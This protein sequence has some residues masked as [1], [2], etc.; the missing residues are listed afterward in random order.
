VCRGRGYGSELVS[1][2]AETGEAMKHVPQRGGFL[3][4]LLRLLPHLPNF[5]RLFW[6]LFRDPRVPYYL[7]GM[8]VATV[9]YVLSPFDIVTDFVPFV[10]QIDDLVLLLLAGYYFIRWSPRDVVREHVAAIDEDFRAKF[11]RWRF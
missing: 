6:R 11:Q 5:A 2:T 9:L 4:Y 8:V 3:L 1:T 10:G 7:K